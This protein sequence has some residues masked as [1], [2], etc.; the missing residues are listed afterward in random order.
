MTAFS[1]REIVS[2]LDRFIIGQK[3]AKRAVAIALRNRWR[4]QQLAGDI[5]E[6]VQPKNILMIG[7]T[8]VGKT[9]IA[10]RLA[11]LA[12]APFI[13]VEATKFTEVGYVGRD[14]EQII[15]DLVEVAIGQ[16]REKM[17]K[18]VHA[19]AELA[20]EER[21]V[22][23]LV[24]ETAGADTKQKFRKMLREGQLDDKEIEIETA[25]QG[26]GMP[27]FEIPGM[28]G[29]QMGM[30][31]LND[32]FGKAFGGRTKKRRM[33]VA[34]SY[35]VLVDEEADNLLDEEKVVREA[36]ESVEQNGI[37]FLD[38]IDKICARAER[39]GAD[40]SREGV[41]RDLLPLIEGTTVATKHGS[42]KTDFVLFIASGAFHLSKPS[43]LLPELQGRL[44]NRVELKALTRD[45]FRRILTEPENSLIRQYT[46][47]MATE[48]VTLDITDEAIDALA[49]LTVDINRNVENI[50]AR[51]L[52]TVMEKLLDEISFTASDRGG[53]TVKIDAA[54][55]KKHVGDLAQ[56]TDLSKFIL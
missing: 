42:V 12:E 2:E 28:P 51:R 7:P 1:P 8:G 20:A 44:P 50:G 47:L 14:V 6:E 34:E 32:M 36:I 30:L 3:D 24:G 52:H 38:E 11:K 53:E 40:V 4:R 33:T 15:R 35:K 18:S 46:A 5:R 55:V 17:R 23:A 19:K 27:T 9:E 16:V 22:S 39:S 10:R 49:D 37:V 21:V 29:A 26:G 31:N 43:D 13:K 45:D 25:D 54:Y 48:E 41:Q 56:D